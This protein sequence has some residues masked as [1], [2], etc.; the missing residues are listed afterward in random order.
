MVKF[1][2]TIDA[3]AASIQMQI[4]VYKL[5]TS[6]FLCC[7]KVE[8][9]SGSNRAS[10]FESVELVARGWFEITSTITPELYDT[11]SNYH[12]LSLIFV[13]ENVTGILNT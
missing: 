1:T 3:N 12:Y 6:W 2:L 7:Q 9:N 5:I 10:N 4:I 11:K 8:Y 13:M